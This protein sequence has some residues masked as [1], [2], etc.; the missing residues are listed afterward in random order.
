MQVA[1]VNAAMTAL[2]KATTSF[3]TE[4]LIVQRERRSGDYTV[5][6]YF[7]SKLLAEVPLSAFFPCMAG[8]VM[9]KLCGLNPAPGRLA[10]FLGILTVVRD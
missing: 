2:I 5:F 9:Y 8:F 1:A 6:P 3:V 10:R 7:L 4:K